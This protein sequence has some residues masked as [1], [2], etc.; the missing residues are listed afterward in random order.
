MNPTISLLNRF[1]LRCLRAL[2]LSTA[3]ILLLQNAACQRAPLRVSKASAQDSDA[4]VLHLH[5]KNGPLRTS[6]RLLF[7]RAPVSILRR[8]D[9]WLA[10]NVE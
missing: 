7:W 3:A 4:H 2:L 9:D 5:R 6:T 1:D 10:A 8:A